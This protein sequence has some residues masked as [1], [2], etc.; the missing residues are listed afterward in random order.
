[1]LADYESYA[2]CQQRVDELYRDPDEWTRRAIL[3]IAGMGRF[4]SDRAVLEYANSI[5]TV[6]PVRH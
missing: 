4:S 3:N 6:N 1:V 5:W 2:A